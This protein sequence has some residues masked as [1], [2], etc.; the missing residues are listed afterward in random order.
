[1]SAFDKKEHLGLPY[2]NNNML[3]DAIKYRCYQCSSF[4]QGAASNGC[5]PLLLQALPSL[6]L[7]PGTRQRQYKTM[8]KAPK[9]SVSNT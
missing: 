7:T 2:P 8:N 9:R 6:K 4:C 1:M 5:K 3:S